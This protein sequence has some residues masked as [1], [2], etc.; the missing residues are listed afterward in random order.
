MRDATR[1]IAKPRER[2]VAN[3]PVG[4]R[5]EKAGNNQGLAVLW[6]QRP[7]YTWRRWQDLLEGWLVTAVT[8]LAF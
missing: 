3:L 5:R 2:A 7:L 4:N 8:F 6:S 1:H